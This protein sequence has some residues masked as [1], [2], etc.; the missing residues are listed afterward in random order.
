MLH[1]RVG[2]P[3][4]LPPASARWNSWQ[5]GGIDLHVSLRDYQG[6]PVTAT[7]VKQNDST[8]QH[9]LKDDASMKCHQRHPCA[10]PV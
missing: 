6:K 4:V 3:L 9:L 5:H 7:Y 8:G 1:V 10:P 2:L